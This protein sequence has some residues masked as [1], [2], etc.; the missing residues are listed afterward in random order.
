MRHTAPPHLQTYPLTMVQPGDTVRVVAIHG[1]YRLR[2]RLADLGLSVGMPVR[3]IQGSSTGPLL[4]AFREDARLAV[5]HGVAHKII[6]APCDHDH[7][8]N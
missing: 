3:V 5:G 6:V 8:A 1:G 7:S 2:K 4:I